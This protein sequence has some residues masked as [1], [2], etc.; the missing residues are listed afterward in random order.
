MGFSMKKNMFSLLIIVSL[1]LGCNDDLFQY[2]VHTI[3]SSSYSNQ[4]NTLNLIQV[5]NTPPSDPDDF[6]VALIADSH[7]YF[8]VLK[9]AVNSINANPSI[10]FVIHLGDFAHNGMLFQYE[11]TMEILLKL[12][13]PFLVVMGN[14]DCLSNGREIFNS[15]L[16][17]SDFSFVYGHSYFIVLNDNDWETST[18]DAD[19]FSTLVKAEKDNPEVRHSFAFSHIPLYSDNR[20]PS[21][22]QDKIMDMLYENN[23][24]MTIHGHTHTYT[25]IEDENEVTTLV[26]GD[27][28][29]MIITLLHVSGETVSVENIAF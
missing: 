25:W 11:K 12:Q 26:L 21:E 6:T 9:K 2:S 3:K 14:H 4:Y 15:V 16:G 20:F 23:F 13:K 8:D 10:N 1:L 24:N 18:I 19:E 27:L 29:D 28:D 7:D 22:L 17:P 5:Q